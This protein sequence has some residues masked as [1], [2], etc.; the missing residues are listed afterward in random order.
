MPN[1]ADYRFI[2]G[3]SLK[4]KFAHLA[5]VYVTCYCRRAWLQNCRVYTL[6]LHGRLGRHLLASILKSGNGASIIP[7]VR[8][9]FL[10]YTNGLLN[11]KRAINL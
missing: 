9:Y 5:P 11:S 10:V 4:W 7:L 8:F 6:Q 3:M 2:T 1:P